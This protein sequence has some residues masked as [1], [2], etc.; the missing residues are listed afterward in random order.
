MNHAAAYDMGR[1][2]LDQHGLQQWHLTFDRA[3]RRAGVCRFRDTT[4]SL[5]RHAV[6]LQTEEQVRETVLHEIAHAKAG[7]GAGHGPVWKRM[8]A[9][10][11][12]EPVRCLPPD[13][14]MPDGDLVGTCAAGHQITRHRRPSRVLLCTGC[15]G[16]VRGRVFEWTYLGAPVPMLA[17]Y[18]AELALLESGPP[19]LQRLVDVGGLAVGCRVVLRGP[20][21]GRWAGRQGVIAKVNRT[22]YVVQL[23]EGRVIVPFPLV[24]PVGDRR[25]G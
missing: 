18:N 8:A 6:G 14:P 23:P 21:C 15:R 25:V 2:L 3:K 10:V 16:D 1:R 11:G 9:A 19:T 24:E 4:I 5:S 22:R 12:A 13:V 20:E 17:S 7:P